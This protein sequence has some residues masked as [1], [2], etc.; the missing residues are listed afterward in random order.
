MQTAVI[1]EVPASA[2]Q[3][4]KPA[5]AMNSID[6]ILIEKVAHPHDKD[7]DRRV[8]EML[9]QFLGH[10]NREVRVRAKQTL[11]KLD[12]PITTYEEAVAV[13]QALDDI[14]ANEQ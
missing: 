1:A 11:Y 10:S 14:A 9:N 2:Q 3:E 5:I 8:R 12:H 6:S 4:A 7:T 13:K